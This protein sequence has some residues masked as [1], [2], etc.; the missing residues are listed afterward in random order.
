MDHS[1]SKKDVAC[2]IIIDDHGKR[3]D[4][5]LNQS[6]KVVL[7][8]YCLTTELTLRFVILY[9][10]YSFIYRYKFHDIHF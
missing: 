6:P 2:L 7:I 8:D 5:D 1:R 3:H 10:E 4:L 9:Q